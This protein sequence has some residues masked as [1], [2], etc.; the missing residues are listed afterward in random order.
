MHESWDKLKH[1]DGILV[2]GGFGERG[3]KGKIEAIQFARENKI[4]Y[5]GICLGMQLAVIEFC[6]NVL[7]ISDANSEEFEE[8]CDNK[9][10]VFMPEI[11]KI[12]KGGTMRL[13]ARHTIINDPNSLACKVYNGAS[14]VYER[15]RHRYEVN[16]KYREMIEEQG[17]IFSGEDSNRERMEI[18]ELKDH[19]F[20][21]GTQYHPEFTSKPFQPNPS[22]F[23]FVKASAGLFE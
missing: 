14:S 18:I 1:A 21:F 9:V 12:T 19:P 4:P 8:S 5:L 3:A 13:G 22:F 2:P 16:I 20:F 6:R 23:A 17:L 11:S 15:H 10:I 7:G